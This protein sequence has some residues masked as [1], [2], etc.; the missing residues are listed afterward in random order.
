MTLEEFE[1]LIPINDRDLCYLTNIS[2]GIQ[3]FAYGAY[4]KGVKENKLM[5]TDGVIEI[6]LPIE[7]IADVKKNVMNF[8]YFHNI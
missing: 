6:Y 8:V 4:Y 7:C 5:F 1:A 2:G 3:R